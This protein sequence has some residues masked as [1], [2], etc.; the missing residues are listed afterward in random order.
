MTIWALHLPPNSRKS[1]G[2]SVASATLASKTEVSVEMEETD[3]LDSYQTT[4]TNGHRSR[5]LRIELLRLPLT[6]S[7]ADDWEF[8]RD[9]RSREQLELAFNTQAT[10]CPWTATTATAKK[11]EEA[12]HTGPFCLGARCRGTCVLGRG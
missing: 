10:L 9:A 4:E 1:G 8:T 11:K 3:W 12:I 5:S 6:W 7:T 2:G